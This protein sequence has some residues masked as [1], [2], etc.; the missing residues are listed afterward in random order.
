[1][2]TLHDIANVM[3]IERY[4]LDTGPKRAISAEKVFAREQTIDNFIVYKGDR[5]LI[6]FGS[7]EKSREKI[8]R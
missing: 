3:S 5:V 4:L 1:M 2:M 7:Q 6:L 8:I